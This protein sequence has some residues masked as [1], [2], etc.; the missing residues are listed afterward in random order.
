M[1]HGNLTITSD[2]DHVIVAARF[3]DGAEWVILDTYMGSGGGG[4]DNLC[5]TDTTF[6]CQ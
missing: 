2:R 3:A 1:K 6:I 4:V 5:R